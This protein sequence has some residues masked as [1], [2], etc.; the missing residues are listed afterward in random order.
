MGQIALL[1]KGKGPGRPMGAY[2]PLLLSEA[3]AYIFHEGF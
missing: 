1:S 3:A 2:P